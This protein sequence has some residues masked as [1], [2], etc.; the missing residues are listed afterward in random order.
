MQKRN[1]LVERVSPSWAMQLVPILS[2]I[3]LFS[4]AIYILPAQEES[5]AE[6]KDTAAIMLVVSLTLFAIFVPPMFYSLGKLKRDSVAELTTFG[7]TAL[8]TRE[9][10]KAL[11]TFTGCEI[12][13]ENVV[14]T[15]R[16]TIPGEVWICDN[17]EIQKYSW[18]HLVL[19]VQKNILL[20]VLPG[21]RHFPAIRMY[22]PNIEYVEVAF[23]IN[24]TD[25]VVR[26]TMY[27]C[28]PIFSRQAK[29][30]KA[31]NIGLSAREEEIMLHRRRQTQAA[32]ARQQEEAAAQ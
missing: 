19:W 24:T 1:E 2:G 21:T 6:M 16:G 23:K 4:R 26:L 8:D 27:G 10:S 11:S 17:R 31:P 30:K 29:P 14:V 25:Y 22:A 7:R 13:K 15:G 9:I 12:I 20:Q 28:N 32:I 5:L 18:Q 3:L